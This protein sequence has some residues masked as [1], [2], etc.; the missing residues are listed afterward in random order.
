MNSTCATIFFP[1]HFSDSKFPMS[2]S[3]SIKSCPL[4]LVD[5]DTKRATRSTVPTTCGSTCD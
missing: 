2:Q 4:V 3:S 1:I 5:A